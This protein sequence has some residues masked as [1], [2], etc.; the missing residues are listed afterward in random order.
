MSIPQWLA[1]AGW[2]ALAG[3]ALLLGAALAYFLDLG[4]R[5][6]AGIMALGSGVLISALAFDL[7]DEAYRRG[8]FD[9]TSAGFIGGAV[10]YTGAN[11]LLARAGAK[12]RK[13]S[14]DRQAE[15]AENN[16]FAIFVGSLLDGIP[17]S[18][19]IGVSLLQG[20]DGSFVTVVAIFLSNVPEGLSSTAGMRRAGRSALYVFGL[21]G[22]AVL[23]SG[24]AALAG[25]LLLRGVSPDV[26]AAITAVAAGAILAMLT[27]TMVPEAFAEAHNF[28][29]LITAVGFLC[30]FM[31]SKLGA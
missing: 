5:L 17:E 2:G 16:G 22:A 19:A 8:G 9:S 30:A 20:G 14:G 25:N 31:L 26:I 1:A 10:V 23:A 7:M 3:S 15:P 4:Q 13:R 28:A 27:D 29:G 21:W 11:W 24:A 6:I 18:V 12:H